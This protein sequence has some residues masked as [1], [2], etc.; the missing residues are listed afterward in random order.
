[1]PWLRRLGALAALALLAGVGDAAVKA[2]TLA[3]IMTVSADTLD[4]QI[5]AKE[6]FR[7]D[8]PDYED[9]VF[10]RITVTGESMRTGEPVTTELVYVG[11]HDPA[12]G[13]GSSEMPLFQDVRIGNRVVL[14]YGEDETNLSGPRQ[15]WGLNCVF[16]VESVV[17]QPVVMGKGEGFAFPENVTLAEARDQ[18][19]ALH[20]AQVA[21]QASGK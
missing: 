13:Y 4:A 18:V 15:V 10:T 19:R 6:T 3:E 12:D 21:Q 14:F 5:V 7:V 16:R 11:S 2:F 8:D 9:M 17:G 1:M 20:L